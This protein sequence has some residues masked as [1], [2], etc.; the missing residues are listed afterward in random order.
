[1]RANADTVEGP[2][3]AAPSS[4]P[5]GADHVAQA[6]LADPSLRSLP[7]AA[8]AQAAGAT[9]DDAI[10]GIA[11]L[12]GYAGAHRRRGDH[13]Q[14]QPG[15]ARYVLLGSLSLDRAL[16]HFDSRAS[17]GVISPDVAGDVVS[18]SGSRIVRREDEDVRSIEVGM[19]QGW[20]QGPGSN[21]GYG[22]GL[23]Q[24]LHSYGAFGDGGDAYSG[25]QPYAGGL[26]NVGDDGRILYGEAGDTNVPT[27][28]PSIYG[29]GGSGGGGGGQYQPAPP[30]PVVDPGQYQ[31]LP[32]PP[33]PPGPAPVV[34]AGM[35][36][37]EI[38][39]LAAAVVGGWLFLRKKR[40][41]R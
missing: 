22:E 26:H 38:G 23:P 33:A 8:L 18:R 14:P 12:V 30:V 41:R 19:L 31:P 32:P 37:T 5:P 11:A 24:T 7:P 21:F 4:L 3:P 29:G 16:E 13:L 36:M 40:G 15:I 10:E 39:V 34:Q 2:R 35:S 27:N 25:D 6:L 17:P 20:P 1:V 28:D 9:V